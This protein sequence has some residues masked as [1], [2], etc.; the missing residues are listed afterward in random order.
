MCCGGSSVAEERVVAVES[1]G[2]QRRAQQHPVRAACASLCECLICEL[3]EASESRDTFQCENA[4]DMSGDTRT[5]LSG[6]AA[7]A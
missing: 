7:S 5:G 1:G 4:S 2:R 3:P 6:S